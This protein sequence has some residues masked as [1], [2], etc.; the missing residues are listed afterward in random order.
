MRNKKPALMP[1]SIQSD[2][3]HHPKLKDLLPSVGLDVMMDCAEGPASTSR[4]T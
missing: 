3:L 4:T 2:T 1:S